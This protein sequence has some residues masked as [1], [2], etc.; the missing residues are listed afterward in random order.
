MVIGWMSVVTSPIVLCR[1]SNFTSEFVYIRTNAFNFTTLS[2]NVKQYINLWQYPDTLADQLIFDC[3]SSMYAYF[4]YNLLLD[5]LY[6]R[7]L[8]YSI[9]Y[10]RI[11]I[12]STLAITNLDNTKSS[13]SRIISN[14]LG[15]TCLTQRNYYT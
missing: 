11:H 7:Y 1:Q 12:Q 4:T 2:S 6:M 15:K 9:C 3:S 5:G 10:N 8:M 14:P 13:I